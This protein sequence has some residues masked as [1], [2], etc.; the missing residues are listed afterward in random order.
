MQLRLVKIFVFMFLFISSSTALSQS[1]DGSAGAGEAKKEVKAEKKIP[2]EKDWAKQVTVLNTKDGRVKGHKKDLLSLIGEKKSAKTE[3]QKKVIIDQLIKVYGTYQKELTIRNTLKKKLKY[4]F[5]NKGQVIERKYL[6]MRVQSLEAMEE[7]QGID[8][9]LTKVR[10][11]INKKYAPFLPK[12][13][14]AKQEHGP[15]L[16][17]EDG[18]VQKRRSVHDKVIIER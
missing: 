15:A 7:E 6:P 18:R 11:K 2:D 16:I 3:K 10:K 12:E 13:L 4:K 8:G 14:K 5:P 9:Q 1:D 17:E